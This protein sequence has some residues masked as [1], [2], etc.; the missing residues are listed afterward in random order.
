M[1]SCHQPVQLFVALDLMV[2]FARPNPAGLNVV[3]ERSE[4][5]LHSKGTSSPASILAEGSWG[6][7]SHRRRQRIT[8]AAGVA[9]RCERELGLTECQES[10]S[11][12]V[13]IK[14]R[15]ERDFSEVFKN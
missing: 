12:D 14:E 8:A 10:Y 1:F 7:P 6:L 9:L 3:S 4:C 15:I 2:S 13:A 5:L 11:G